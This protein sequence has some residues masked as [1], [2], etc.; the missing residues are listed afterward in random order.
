MIFFA[1]AEEI[2]PAE[3]TPSGDR[4]KLTMGERPAITVEAVDKEEKGMV[5]VEEEGVGRE[6][7][8]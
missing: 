1:A 5:G 7:E 4:D 6:T 3:E 2:F 8:A